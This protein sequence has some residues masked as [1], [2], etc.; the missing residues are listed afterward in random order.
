VLSKPSAEL[1]K[2]LAGYVRVEWRYDGAGGRVLKWA[3]AHGNTRED[4]AYLAW[5]LDSKLEEVSRWLDRRYIAADFLKW[6]EDTSRD[7]EVRAAAKAKASRVNFVDLSAAEDPK[8]EGGFS[9]EAL[10]KARE[11][12]ERRP[13]LIFFQLPGTGVGLA[14]K[15]RPEE[16][17]ACREFE[18]GPLGAADVI[19]LSHE[20]TCF[21]VDVTSELNQ[22]LAAKFGADKLPAVVLWAH[23]KDAKPQFLGRKTAA[24]DLAAAMKALVPAEK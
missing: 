24:K 19:K 11:P 12:E 13:I 20:F 4:P 5:T 16:T 14:A 2:A 8:A 21:R 15:V 6:L 1:K 7:W 23:G 10:D 9:V 18:K 3:K 17:R 22:R